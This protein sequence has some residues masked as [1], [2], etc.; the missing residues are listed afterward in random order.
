MLVNATT[1][2]WEYE[3][4]ET[5]ML[6]RVVLVPT[7]FSHNLHSRHIS[8]SS[9]LLAPP[10]PRP[11]S[12]QMLASSSRLRRSCALGLRCRSCSRPPLRPLSILEPR[13]HAPPPASSTDLRTNGVDE[14]VADWGMTGGGGIRGRAEAANWGTGRGGGLGRARFSSGLYT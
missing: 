6:G 4:G 7:S 10:Y 1:C 14:E 12:W 2:E 11:S 5:N 9:S 3:E 13:R 8:S